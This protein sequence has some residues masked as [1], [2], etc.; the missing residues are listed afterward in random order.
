[1]EMMANAGMPNAG[2]PA[3]PLAKSDGDTGSANIGT[4]KKS[5]A[6][7]LKGPGMQKDFSIFSLAT[8]H[9]SAVY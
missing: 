8:A 2:G 1:M 7:I 5:G 3:A 6:D 4:N 9:S